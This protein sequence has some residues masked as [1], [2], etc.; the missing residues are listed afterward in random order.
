MTVSLTREPQA[1]SAHTFDVLVIGGGIYGL[2]VACDAAQRGL[3]VALVERNDFGSGTSFNHLRTIHGGL[4]YLQTLDLARA[5][6]SIRERRAIARVAPWAVQPLAFVLPL[7]HSVLRGPLAMRA[8]FL[9]DGR[10]A[11]DRNDGVPETH[12]LPAGR[13]ISREAAQHAYPELQSDDF[14][15]AAVW[16]D[17]VAGD[18][19]RLTLAWGL[20]AAAHGAVL[21]NYTVAESLTA[22]G[23]RV[24]GATVVD[25]TSGARLTVR[26]TT[27]VNATGGGLNRL[28]DPFHAEVR[29]PLLQALNLVTRLPAPSA[30]IGGRSASGRNLFVVPWRGRALFGTWESRTTCAPDDLT[31]GD[32]HVSAFI[33]ELNQA[34]PSY[35]LD[36][37]AVTLVHRGVVPARVRADGSPALEGHDVIFEH[38]AQGLAGLISVAGTKYTT[39]RAVAERIVDRLFAWL[40]RPHRPSISAT[41]P[42]PSV[43]M[44]ADALLRHA[45]RSE[46]VVT[47][48]DAVMRRT[49]LG[50][51]GCPDTDTI[52]HAARIVGEQL[53][54]SI[55]RQQTEIAALR[56]M[57]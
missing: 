9:L 53:G 25:Q 7:Q 21:A 42:L 56:G 11:G 37:D 1:L 13:V 49:T 6:E 46:M 24:T 27:V 10:I 39:A 29:L 23:G 57:Y 14:A 16:Y 55:D 33:E 45:A 31:V 2:T 40:D 19:D 20:S 3:R 43:D 51:L 5:R 47:L 35:R 54:W 52:V 38:R 28:L 4:R 41:T 26:A 48:A 32:A 12:R 15:A 8:G 36:A 18:A 34:F 44:T 50:A 22:D 30:A 17:Y